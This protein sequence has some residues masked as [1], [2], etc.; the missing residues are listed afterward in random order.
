MWPM[1][2]PL[3]AAVVLSALLGACSSGGNSEPFGSSRSVQLTSAQTERYYTAVQTRLLAKGFLRTDGGTADAELSAES[4]ARN[5]ENI[6]MYDEFVLRQGRFLPGRRAASLRRWTKPVRIL[7]TFGDSVSKE[8][9]L[10]DLESIEAY[11]KRLQQLTGHRIELSDRDPNFH[12]LIM[13]SEE[14][15]EFAP[16]LLELTPTIPS[17]M[18]YYLLNSPVQTFCAAY[19]NYRRKP[20]SDY[21]SALVI[22]KAEHPD[23]MRL[24][25]I[26][27]EMAQA[28]G[29][30]NDRP[31][32]RPSI[33]NDDEEFALLTKHD[34]MLLKIL[35]DPRLQVGMS[36]AAAR[37]TVRKIAGELVSGASG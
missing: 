36:R 10:Q 15:R 33:F 20:Y 31:D 17:R 21:K 24:S 34:E 19:S 27:E 8:R 3:P 29:L 2:L 9:Q 4:L 7:V 18:A 11:V 13:N 5:F 14:M 37:P 6:A 35:Y 12:V 16:R 25:C 28:L 30:T 1:Q 32:A 26:H 22:I 23:L